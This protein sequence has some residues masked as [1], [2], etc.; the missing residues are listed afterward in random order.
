MKLSRRK[1][2]RAYFR[3]SSGVMHVMQVILA[4]SVIGVGGK[5]FFSCVGGEFQE[6]REEFEEWKHDFGV[7]VSAEFLDFRNMVLQELWLLT[8]MEAV[9]FGNI[10]Y[11]DIIEYPI[12]KSDGRLRY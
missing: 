6:D 3:C 1:E 5:E 10:V 4:T 12:Y 11:L 9:E 7:A 8:R 2:F